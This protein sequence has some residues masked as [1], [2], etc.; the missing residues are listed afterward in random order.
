MARASVGFNLHGD[1]DHALLSLASRFLGILGSRIA[2]VARTGVLRRGSWSGIPAMKPLGDDRALGNG[3]WVGVRVPRRL[4][5]CARFCRPHLR[6]SATG[7]RNCWFRL[8]SRH[9][10]CWCG[11][12]LDLWKR[13]RGGSRRCGDWLRSWLGVCRRLW[14]GRRDD[15]LR[16]GVNQRHVERLRGAAQG[17]RTRHAARA[18]PKEQQRVEE[19]GGGKRDDTGQFHG[20]PESALAG[21]RLL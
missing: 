17:Q 7:R 18:K 8:G 2:P 20:L 9:R 11:F 13:S 19:G 14:G 21:W 3:L 6:G 1:Q 4:F 12:G 16:F 10:L 5:R 15:S